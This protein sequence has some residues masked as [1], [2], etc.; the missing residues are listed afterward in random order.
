[1]QCLHQVH[2]LCCIG[3]WF[4]NKIGLTVSDTHKARRSASPGH[5][6]GRGREQECS[7]RLKSGRGCFC[8][9]DGRF[10]FLSLRL[11][12]TL[13]KNHA[14]ICLKLSANVYDIFLETDNFFSR[15]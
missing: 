2:T 5:H 13:D 11:S 12:E 8:R 9:G 7:G 4:A 1:M 10:Q 14:V 15:K 6:T 3:M